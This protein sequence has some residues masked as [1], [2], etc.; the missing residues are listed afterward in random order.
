MALNV[1]NKIF[2]KPPDRE[3]L[4]ATLLPLNWQMEE[5]RETFSFPI[6]GLFRKTGITKALSPKIGRKREN[7]QFYVL[8]KVPFGNSYMQNSTAHLSLMGN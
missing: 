8:L 3:W 1:P 4:Y 7:E 6:S 5:G 2:I